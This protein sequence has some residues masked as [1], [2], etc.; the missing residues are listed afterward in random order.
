M[1][2]HVRRIPRYK[3]DL[4]EKKEEIKINM[5]RSMVTV[6]ET[7]EELNSV[8]LMSLEKIYFLLLEVYLHD[9][10]GTNLPLQEQNSAPLLKHVNI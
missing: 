2:W 6:K 5:V 3:L 1:D 7:Y 10:W 4:F 9:R 8:R